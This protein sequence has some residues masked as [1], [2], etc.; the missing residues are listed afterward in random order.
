MFC[1]GTTA[2]FRAGWRLQPVNSL[3]ALENPRLWSSLRQ[4]LPRRQLQINHSSPC[5]P[6]ARLPKVVPWSLQGCRRQQSS[7]PPA[8]KTLKSVEEK[9]SNSH[10][11]PEAPRN[12]RAEQRKADWAILREM[13]KYL[14][15]KDNFGFRLRVVLALGLLVAA[16]LLNVQVPFFFKRIIDGLNIDFLGVGGTVWT[17]AGTMILAY[18]LARIGS[19]LFQE[20][21]NAVFANVAQKAIRQVARNVFDHLL[22]LDL[23]FHISRET[24]GLSRAIDRGTK[25]I[26][27]LLTSMVF[28][29]IPIAFEITLVSGILTY[30]YGAKFAVVT[31]STMALYA[32]FTIQTTAW[33][34]KFRRQANAADNKA[35]TIDVDSLLNFET[36]KYFN[37]ESYQVQIYDAALRDYEK[38]SLKIATSLA[39]LNSGQNI[40]FSS[41][42]TAMMFLAAH[43]ISTGAFTVGDLVMINQLV[44]QL[45]IPLNFLGTVYRELRQ[46][47]IDMELLFNLQKVNITVKEAPDA[48]P[49]QPPSA[50]T[51]QQQPGEIRFENI[52]F[53]YSPDRPIL[54]DVSFSVP[55]GRRVAIVGASGSGKST[56]LRLLFRFYDNQS[57]RITIDGQDIRSLKLDSLRRAIGVVPQDTILFNDTIRHNIRYGRLDATNE[58]VE[59]AARRARIHDAI[60]AFPA[61]YDTRVGERG[62]MLSGGEKQRIAISR[63]LLK[64]PLIMFF[65]EATSAMD[66]RTEQVLLSNINE[67]IRDNQRTSIFIAHRLKTI[68]GCGMCEKLFT[69]LYK[70]NPRYHHRAKGWIRCRVRYA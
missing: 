21:R 19:T 35:A 25:G 57:G 33:R 69:L 43:G 6:I 45:S 47:L 54:R 51:S 64:N 27:F 53:G 12:E 8:N 10:I 41:S 26:S 48:Q 16:K 23:Q 46:S 14:W 50:T 52:G 9:K 22:R 7:Q 62:M 59:S 20:I 30:N 18:G 55:A 67:L 2:L 34:T 63:M 66:T 36:V 31:V 37:N 38:A 68:Q 1:N 3:L 56:I 15:P 17:V 5:Q 42:L 58:E 4:I 44:F 60:M 61:G 11:Q 24:G 13:A 39:L 32:F 40:I 29:I 49:L 70:T 28:H 65:D